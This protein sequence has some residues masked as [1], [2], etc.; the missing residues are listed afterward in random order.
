MKTPSLPTS[1]CSLGPSR[2]GGPSEGK[3]LGRSS[4]GQ[5]VNLS[6]EDARRH[7]KR[8]ITYAG[9]IQWYINVA[10]VLVRGTRYV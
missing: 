2:L 3:P 7:E 5:Q 8:R 9:K 10:R 6:V 1:G 4:R